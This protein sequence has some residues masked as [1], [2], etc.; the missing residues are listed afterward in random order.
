MTE[1]QQVATI[2]VVLVGLGLAGIAYAVDRGTFD[3]GSADE[4]AEYVEDRTGNQF[5]LNGAWMAT[6]IRAKTRI[7]DELAA[8]RVALEN[9]TITV[10]VEST[11]PDL[12][13]VA[14]AIRDIASAIGGEGG[15]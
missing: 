14:D 7:A 12:T 13:G 11:P 9:L 1:R 2:G 6:D 4:F 3:F 8:I 5:P 15:E 10:E